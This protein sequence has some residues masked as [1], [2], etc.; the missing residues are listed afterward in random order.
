M[1]GGGDDGPPALPDVLVVGGG[2]AGSASALLLARRGWTVHLLERSYFPRAKACGECLNP[3]AVSVLGRLGLLERVLALEPAVLEGWEIRSGSAAGRACFP[4]GAG[5]GLALPR[6]QL[7]QALLAAARSAGVAVEHGLTVRSVGPADSR[8][9]R[10]ALVRERDGREGTRRGRVLVGADGLRSVVARAAGGPRRP[11]ELRKLSLTLRVRG[12][13]AGGRLGLLVLDGGGTVGLAPVSAARDLWNLSVVV[14]AE[15]WGR[16]VAADP[17]AFAI[18]A[19]ERAALGWTEGPE[20]LAGPWASG[21]F[22]RPMRA[23]AATGIFLVGDAAGYYDPLTGQGI[24]R[25]LRSA[26]LAADAIDRALRVGRES[27]GSGGTPGRV[28][29]AAARRYRVRH[30]AAF[31]TG[32]MV[33]RVVEEA[34][35]R[36][37]LREPLV[38]RLG[39]RPEALARLFAVTGDAISAIRLLGPGMLGP[40]ILPARRHHE[41]RAAHRAADD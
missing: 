14:A 16:G 19:A 12:R 24:Y 37:A 40:L 8:G 26:E 33:Q 9:C 35:S 28:L 34:I 3:G 39:R 10:T 17:L 29:G 6:A 41:G 4:R 36:D 32:R 22:D 11:P 21:P 20:V 30:A 5:T 25:A 38:E 27:G 15:R 31:T 2:P 23:V 13:R 7:D 18:D 1:R